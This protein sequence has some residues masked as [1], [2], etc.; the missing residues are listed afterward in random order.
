MSKLVTINAKM[1]IAEFSADN[2]VPPKLAPKV[3]NKQTKDK[4][5]YT[6]M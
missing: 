4:V 5:A 6:E 3:Q 2:V 1:V